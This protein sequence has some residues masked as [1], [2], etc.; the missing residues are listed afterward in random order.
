MP[1]ATFGNLKSLPKLTGS[2]RPPRLRKP[3]VTPHGPRHLRLASEPQRL[4]VGPGDPPLGFV[5]AHTSVPEWWVYWA[6]SKVL[7]TPREVRKP[8]F[9]GGEDWSYQS[10]IDGGRMIAG[11]QVMDFVVVQAHQTLGLRLQTEF[12]HL[13]AN[14]EQRVRDLYL[15]QHQKAVDKVVDIFGQDFLGDASGKAA[16]V[17]VA[18]A[19]KG[20]QAP[21][22]I[23]FGTFVRI[24]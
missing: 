1:V 10:A 8:P 11:G 17:V 6:L 18:R 3:S 23:K 24:R 22:P 13:A 2:S 9:V 19:L 7:G 4:G 14:G 5:G 15:K 20:E 16:C 12:F 21:D